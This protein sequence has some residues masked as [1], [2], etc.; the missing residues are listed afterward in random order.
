MKLVRSV[1]RRLRRPFLTR[2]AILLYHRVADLELDPQ[3]LSVTPAHFDEHLQV[4]RKLALPRTLAQI[5][6]HT[7]A[8]AV[9]VTFDDGYEDNLLNAAPALARNGVP[10]TFFITS[11]VL[12]KNR[13]FFWDD[14]ERLLLGPHPLPASFSLEIAGERIEMVLEGTPHDPRWTVLRPDLSAR[15]LLY[16]RLH[17]ALGPLPGSERRAVLERIAA[18]AGAGVEARQTHRMLTNNQLANLSGLPGVEIGAHSVTHPVLSSLPPEE[19]RGE[20]AQSK[21]VLEEI[22]AR[23]V[24]SFAYPFGSEDDYGPVAVAAVR[25]AG[26]RRAASTTHDT[27]WRGSDRFRLPRILVR[28]CDGEAFARLLHQYL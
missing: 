14:L 25:D 12:G 9:A 19:Q 10:A 23:P 26:F 1:G 5:A 18:W 2:G 4:L 22:V 20:I 17:R 8:G 11:G 28:D 24:E 16:R 21:A 13:E 7:E 15:T 6:H 3:L 27:V